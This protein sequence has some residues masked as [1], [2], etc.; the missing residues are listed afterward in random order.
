MTEIVTFI[1]TG[2]PLFGEYTLDLN[3]YLLPNSGSRYD[4]HPGGGF[5]T[6][7]WFRMALKPTA[8]VVLHPHIAMQYGCFTLRGI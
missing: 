6:S 7:F 8:F 3:L 2:K 5:K 4:S 1:K